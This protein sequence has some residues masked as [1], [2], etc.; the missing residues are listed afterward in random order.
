ME[1]NV[2]YFTGQQFGCVERSGLE[3]HGHVPKEQCVGG[4]G[5]PL[6]PTQTPQHSAVLHP[7]P[8]TATRRPCAPHRNGIRKW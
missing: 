5:D 4:G 2:H 1:F 6:F 3:S 8:V 7:L